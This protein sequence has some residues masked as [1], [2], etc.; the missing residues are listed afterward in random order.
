MI[1][2]NLW[3]QPGAGKSTGAAYI[4]SRLKMAGINAELVTEFAKDKVWEDNRK[5]LSNQAYMFGQ[6]YYRLS[7]LEGEVDVVIVDSPLMLS[8]L[9]NNDPKLG[10]DFNQVVRKVAGSYDSLDYLVR[11]V[12]PYNPK[13][14]LQTEDESNAIGERIKSVMD[15]YLGTY[16]TIDGN[17]EG[18]DEVVT[19]VLRY[20]RYSPSNPAN[21][22]R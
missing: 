3:A 6:Q 5:A 14:R 8:L 7:R 12:K 16:K 4:F 10:N 20:M 11:R 13:G 19:D 18:Y 17:T 22:G 9:Y 1:V 21:A 2:C 15:T